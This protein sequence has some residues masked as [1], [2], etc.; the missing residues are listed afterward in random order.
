M[1]NFSLRWNAPF[2]SRGQEFHDF[3]NGYLSSRRD[4]LCILGQGFDPRMTIAWEMIL[5]LGGA[6]K[7]D[8][9]LVAFDEGPNS[10]SKQLETL[11]QNNLTRLNELMQEK[12]S[13]RSKSVEMLSSDGV[14][15]KRTTSSRALHVLEHG[16]DFSGYSDVIIEI[17]AMPRSVFLPLV[18][19]ALYI[20][21]NWSSETNSAAPNLH[22]VVCENQLLDSEI[23][24]IGPDE[25]ADYVQGFRGSMDIESAEQV[26]RVWIPGSGSI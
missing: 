23:R 6:G 9:L 18:A 16:A 26:P 14:R 19:K 2:M 8:C 24:P 4:V 1:L 5:K 3:W 17:S 10:P 13:I 21:D 12:G 15:R 11:T 22:I 7:R 25:V 20:I